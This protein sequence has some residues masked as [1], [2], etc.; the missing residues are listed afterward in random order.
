MNKIKAII[1]N[2][3]IYALLLILVS[4]SLA[5]FAEIKTEKLPDA[6]QYVPYGYKL[7]ADGNGRFST[8]NTKEGKKS[9]PE[10]IKVSSNGSI[11]GVPENA[12]TYELIVAQTIDG[13]DYVKTLKLRILPFDKSLLKTGGED[14]DILGSM[15]ESLKG[16]AN[17]LNGGKM[18]LFENEIH[19]INKKGFYM[20][21]N[22]EKG[23]AKN[24]FSTPKYS[25]LNKIDE[26]ILFFNSYI[27]SKNVDLSSI[28]NAGSLETPDSESPL[29]YNIKYTNRVLMQLEGQKRK[30][31]LN[32]AYKDIENLQTH[33]NSF[34]YLLGEKKEKRLYKSPI[35]GAKSKEVIY[36]YDEKPI[37]ISSFILSNGK[38]IFKAKDGFIYSAFL[39]GN[40]AN[41]VLDKK[42]KLYCLVE[43]EGKTA[44]AYTDN[45]NQLYIHDMEKNE[46][47]QIKNTFASALNAGD[48]VLYFSNAKKK[49]T[50]YQIKLDE[51]ALKATKE[52]KKGKLKIRQ[53]S[54]EASELSKLSASG[55]FVFDNYIGFK[56]K[57]NGAMYLLSQGNSKP[58]LLSK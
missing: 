27:E 22:L 29:K 9:F 25:F 55:I 8:Y 18:E 16:N 33:N 11:F 48:G 51:N 54:L 21:Y 37:Q 1:K 36:F 44:I 4:I 20:S 28:G 39:D 5:S 42:S 17:T 34:Y 10:G 3:A 31:I 14:T 57:K 26:G 19:F 23:K 2:T 43:A 15:D 13:R 58:L 56:H 47:V 12:G 46:S 7:I 35:E 52:I 49:N 24:R 40:I 53:A 32:I 45:K 50:L 38:I 41:R 6:I 30:P